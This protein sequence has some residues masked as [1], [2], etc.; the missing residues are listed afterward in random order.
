MVIGSTAAANL[1][2]VTI[3][4]YI[5]RIVTGVRDMLI[6]LML[7]TFWMVVTWPDHRDQEDDAT[8]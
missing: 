1:R 2:R 6:T 3:M 7:L 4:Q 8:Q 5:V